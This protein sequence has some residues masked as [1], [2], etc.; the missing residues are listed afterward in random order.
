MSYDYIAS[1]GVIIPDTA[2]LQSDV[3]AEYKTGLG[4][5][6]VVTPDSP[7]GVLVQAEVS[8][9]VSVVENNAKLANQINPN[10]AGGIFLDAIWALTG[11]EREQTTRSTAVCNVTG[12]AGTILSTAIRFRDTAGELWAVISATTIGL[13]GIASVNVRAVN[14]GAIAALA[15]SINQIAIGTLGLETVTNPADA[16]PG[17]ESQSDQA[18]RRD[19]RNTLG[20]QGSSVAIHVTSAVYD[21][22]GVRSMSFRENFNS[23]NLVI[24]SITI[25]PHSIYACVDGGSDED[26]AFAL[27]RKSLG[28]GFSGSTTVNVIDPYSGQAIAVK[29]DRPTPVPLL[30]RVTIKATGAL[31]DPQT[32]IRAAIMAYANGQLEGE[33]GFIVNGSASPFELSGAINRQYPT[34]FIKKVEIAV[35]SG[36][37]VYS[38]DVI[39]ILINQIATVTNSS[40]TV[41]VE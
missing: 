19:R 18:A 5:D 35:V 11:G 37:P 39:P 40:I 9:R 7:G 16:T 36:S 8:A 13:D 30:I 23:T 29:F 10:Y 12:I 3:E 17:T 31:V 38:T 4:Q 14:Y 26:V 20:V 32:A 24:D 1:T 22:E 25:P 28:C 21:V 15:G 33:D 6:F 34:I 41:V 2:T 27:L